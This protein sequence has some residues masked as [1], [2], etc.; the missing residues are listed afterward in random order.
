MYILIVDQDNHHNINIVIIGLPAPT[1][2]IA[3]VLTPNSVEV[4]W[5]QLSNV[6]GYFITCTTA[7]SY[8]G[9]KNVIVHGGDTTNHTFTDLVENIPYNIIVQGITGDGR[10]GEHSTT[11]SLITQKACK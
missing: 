3:T 6:T 2:V 8:D 4:T 11:V 7:D 9:D 5:D 1:N 10:K